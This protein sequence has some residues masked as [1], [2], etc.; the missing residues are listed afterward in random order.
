MTGAIDPATAALL[1]TYPVK[2]GWEEVAEL[3][4]L[5]GDRGFVAGGFAVWMASPQAD[6]YPASDIDIFAV[7]PDAAWAIT[8]EICALYGWDYSVSPVAYSL[9]PSPARQ[10]KVTNKR[11]VQVVIPNPKWD[12]ASLSRPC[13]MGMV[14]DGFDFD[15]CRGVLFSPEIVSGDRNMGGY[16][17]HVRVIR[18]PVY[19]LRRIFKY[20]QK[21]VRFSD[22]ELFN[23]LWYLKSANHTQVRRFAEL[24]LENPDNQSWSPPRYDVDDRWFI[25][26]TLF[27][28]MDMHGRAV[29]QSED[30]AF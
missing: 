30:I 1:P 27:E 4:S 14:L 26:Y 13:Q 6:P 10:A 24:Y 21:G 20:M 29:Q 2:R 16:D 15:V 5:V 12:L 18:N 7:T 9:H 3:Y 22:V 25:D 17:A 23:V 8:Q 28:D 19:T 11:R